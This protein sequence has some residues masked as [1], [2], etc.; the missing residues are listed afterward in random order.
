MNALSMLAAVP[1]FTSNQTSLNPVGP[2]AQHIERIFTLIFFITAAAYLLT[3]AATV[4]SVWRNRVETNGFPA[5]EKTTTEQ[6]KRTVAA[7]AGAEPRVLALDVE[8]ALGLAGGQERIGLLL[9]GVHPPHR[10][11][12][13]VQPG[14]R[15]QA[16]EQPAAV[17]ELIGDPGSEYAD[18]DRP[19]QRQVAGAAV[20]SIHT[21]LVE[22]ARL[23]HE[24]QRLH[25][26][27]DHT[28]RE[29]DRAYLRVSYRIRRRIVLVLES[30]PPGRLAMRA[31]RWLFRR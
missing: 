15:G 22:T 26:E 29:L 11:D 23:Q 20:D 28:R 30:T 4:I 7:V 5:P 17:A 19:R 8:R 6:N 31:Y 24:N 21:L 9:V 25:E 13:V 12:R 18:P 3:M 2:M 10:G 27:L 14:V 16:R 1:G